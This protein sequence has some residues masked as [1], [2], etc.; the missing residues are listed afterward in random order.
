MFLFL[1]GCSI[2]PKANYTPIK[3]YDFGRPEQIKSLPI[4][5][6]IKDFTNITPIRK[7][8]IYRKKNVE[9]QPDAYNQWGSTPPLLIT[10]YLKSGIIGDNGKE[11]IKLSGTLIAIDIDLDKNECRMVI[12]YKI[13]MDKTF[14]K[15]VRSFT[16]TYKQPFAKEEPQLFAN[17]FERIMNELSNDIIDDIKASIKQ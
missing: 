14:T 4:T 11:K 3:Y 12:Q 16:K 2:I 10:Q 13:T 6:D 7:Q 5:L 15:P 17:A 1:T 8:M 9:L